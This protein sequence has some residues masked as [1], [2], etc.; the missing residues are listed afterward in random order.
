MEITKLVADSWSKLPDDEK[1]PYLAAAEIDKE[2]YNK[3]LAVINLQKL[4]NPKEPDLINEKLK[5]DTSAKSFVVPTIV[6]TKAEERNGEIAIFTENFLEHNKTAEQ[7]QRILRK[8][9]IDYEQQNSVLEK[10]IENMSNGVD[11]LQ[12]EIVNTK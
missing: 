2:R 3:E 11:K 4:N 6:S 10:H 1:R 7:H 9:T 8:S 12:N 5:T